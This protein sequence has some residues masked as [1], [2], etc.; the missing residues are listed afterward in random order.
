MIIY[1][2][3]IACNYIHMLHMLVCVCGGVCRLKIT[4]TSGKNCLRRQTWFHLD[5]MFRHERFGCRIQ[6]PLEHCWMQ[7]CTSEQNDASLVSH[8]WTTWT[9]RMYWQFLNEE[10]V[11]RKRE[12]Q[13]HEQHFQFVRRASS[14]F[15]PRGVTNVSVVQHGSTS[16]L[17]PVLK[18]GSCTT[19]AVAEQKSCHVLA[20]VAAQRTDRPAVAS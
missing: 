15:Q 19:P 14:C 5:G 4:S 17:A 10:R 12:G 20:S 2:I 1:D 16:K 18:D 13:G 9:W 6:F 11:F 7:W 8:S 3:N